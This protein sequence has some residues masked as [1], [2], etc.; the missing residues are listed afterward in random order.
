MTPDRREHY[1]TIVQARRSGLSITETAAKLGLT[2]GQVQ[3]A[4]RDAGS[5]LPRRLVGKY[6]TDK[7]T[8]L[9]SRLRYLPTQIEKLE[10]KLAQLRAEAAS[11]NLTFKSTQQERA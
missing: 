11:Y 5:R 6:K 2:R 7:T 8:H 1:R 10:A 3:Y 4:L 9:Y